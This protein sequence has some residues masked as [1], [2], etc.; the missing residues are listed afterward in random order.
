[1]FKINEL[2]E[3]LDGKLENI[4]KED[5]GTINRISTDTRTIEN[6]SLF[7]PLKGDNFDGH[8]YIKTAFENGAILA[9][10]EKESKYPILRVKD[11]KDA[12][13]RIAEYYRMKIN[14]IVIGITGSVGKT[15]TKEFISS[16]L[17]EKLN[18]KK[19]YK[20]LN[21]EIGVAKTILELKPEDEVLVIEL[22]MN[23]FGEMHNLSKMV[24]ADYVVL[25]N[26]GLS[27]VGNFNSKDEIVDAKFEIFDFFKEN[28]KII[29]NGD[30]ESFI[31]NIGKIKHESYNFGFNEDNK[32]ICLK[33]DSKGIKGNNI[34]IE[35]LKNK[36]EFNTKASGYHLGFSVMPAIILGEILEIDTEFIIK[37]IE[38]YES[39]DKRM[40]ILNKKDLII[41]N[42]TYN[43]SLMSM[44]SA[45]NTLE[46]S[47]C[48]GKKVAF[49]ADILETGTL[50]QEIHEELG[51]FT[52]SKKIDTIIFT[53]KDVKYSYEKAKEK[54]FE[55]LY[56]FEKKEDFKDTITK[57]L[58]KDSIILLK[59]SR[60]MK[61]EE[62]IDYIQ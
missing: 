33:N 5:V 23:H 61:M 54:G 16:V 7:V 15:T 42:D 58:E 20:N 10:S 36:Y 55:N 28:G 45:L 1:M 18:V 32:I 9:I 53:G 4:K 13:M 39:T 59:G 50:S 44:K 37:G 12:Y 47:E 19:T 22:G 25:T 51:V 48:S 31:K 26:I 62:I 41:I 34:V 60:G 6:G 30:D 29:Y 40:E 27:H 38:K 2:I 14:P 24:R 8:N 52:S 17:E 49:L 56:Y 21:N 57:F 46:E 3:I 11:T 43:A 35:T